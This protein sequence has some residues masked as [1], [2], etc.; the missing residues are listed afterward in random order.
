MSRALSMCLTI[1]FTLTTMSA[2]S[3]QSIEIAELTDQALQIDGTV[4]YVNGTALD[5]VHGVVDRV[6]I[7]EYPLDPDYIMVRVRNADNVVVASTVHALD[8]LEAV[9]VSLGAGDDRYDNSTNVREIVYGGAGGDELWGGDGISWLYGE[10]G[11][12]SL[13][14]DYIDATYG[15]WGGNDVIHG[16]PDRDQIWGGTANDTL[17]GDEG[18]D[19]LTGNSGVDTLCGNDGNDSLIGGI[20][21][22]DSVPDTLWGN[23]GADKFKRAFKPGFNPPVWE[24][25]LADFNAGQGD[26][27]Y[28]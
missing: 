11:E 10:G 17:H 23:A 27:T 2:C 7:E 6:T 21:G 13:Y 5:A 22:S 28:Q 14:G 8:S 18:N 26:S 3:A 24:D 9:I 25:I 4:M 1:A 19:T 20:N 15:A 16:G 12:D